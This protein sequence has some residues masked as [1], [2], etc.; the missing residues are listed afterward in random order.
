MLKD[1]LYF[2]YFFFLIYVIFI[3]TLTVFLDC[4]LMYVSL[5]V[6]F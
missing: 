2:L 5:T 1:V 6:L 3:V 4:P